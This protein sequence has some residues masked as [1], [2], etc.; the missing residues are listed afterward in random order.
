[1]D[2]SL[3]AFV[4]E[5][6]S[7]GPADVDAFLAAVGATSVADL[8]SK[9]DKAL[10]QA[11]IDGGWGTQRICSQMMVNGT[12]GTL[13][14]D[15]SFLLLGQR[16]VVDSQVFANVVY[17]RAGKGQILRMMPDPLDVAYAAFGNGRAT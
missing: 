14:L 11:V 8:P 2:A 9:S 7:M 16:Y 15:R 17:D 1:V 4:G 10:A 12:D 3:R 6:D 5:P 13:P